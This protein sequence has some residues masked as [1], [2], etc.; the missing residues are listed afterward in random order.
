MHRWDFNLLFTIP[1]MPRSYYV[2]EAS[3]LL[4]ASWWRGEFGNYFPCVRNAL[5]ACL[6]NLFWVWF[7]FRV[8]LTF[9]I[10]NLISTFFISKSFQDDGTVTHSR[11]DAPQMQRRSGIVSR[12][13]MEMSRVKGEQ[14]RWKQTVQQQRRNIYDSHTM[15]N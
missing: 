5:F 6:S 13:R 15:L 11:R 9:C 7:F 1:S 8:W 4:R 2:K 10:S 12:V 3:L 14:E